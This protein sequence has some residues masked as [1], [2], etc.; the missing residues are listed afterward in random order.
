MS[1]RLKK[2]IRNIL[3]LVLLFLIFVLRSGF[4]PTPLSAHQRSEQS[5]HYGPSQ[6]VHSEDCAEGKYILGKYDRWVSC[7]SIQ[8][9]FFFFWTI[10]DRSN[11]E[12]DT[13]KPFAFSW[14]TS[15]GGNCN[16]Y[17]IINDQRIKRITLTFNNGQL[18]TQ[19]GFYEDLFLFTWK[20]APDDPPSDYFKDLKGYDAYGNIL[21]AADQS[22]VS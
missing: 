9:K 7:E 14:M 5:L 15:E 6:V 1:I 10:G 11:F 4:Y 8:R 22:K 12:N 2:T 18:M 19:T 21:F 17:G 16:L 3:I 20:L 13:T